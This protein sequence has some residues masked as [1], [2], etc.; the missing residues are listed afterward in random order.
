[1]RSAKLSKLSR[2][3]SSISESFSNTLVES[4]ACGTAVVATDV[5]D[6]RIILGATEALVPPADAAALAQ[7]IAR[8]LDRVRTARSEISAGLRSRIERNFSIAALAAE[9]ERVLLPLIG[10]R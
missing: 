3:A 7:A 2:R 1:M 8:Q 6:A 4:M 10:R 9:T 5:G